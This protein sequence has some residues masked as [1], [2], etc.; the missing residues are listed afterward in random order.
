MRYY[1]N[2]ALVLQQVSTQLPSWAR[3]TSFTAALSYFEAVPVDFSVFGFG[4]EYHLVGDRID[5]GIAFPLSYGRNDLL[6]ENVLELRE[7]LVGDAQIWTERVLEP[8]RRVAALELRHS[9]MI[10]AFCL[11]MDGSTLL[12]REVPDLVYLSLRDLHRFERSDE[13]IW[14][15]AIAQLVVALFGDRPA[16]G[17]EMLERLA[18]PARAWPSLRLAHLGVARVEEGSSI[19][20][21]F[22]ATFD[23]LYAMLA[24]PVLPRVAGF[25]APLE[26]LAR[27][28][29]GLES[30]PCTVLLGSGPL[31]DRV[32]IEIPPGPH[33]ARALA[34]AEHE[35]GI[36]APRI[37]ELE[38][39]AASGITRKLV[40]GW[41]PVATRL[42]HLKLQLRA[43]AAPQWK[44][45]FVARQAG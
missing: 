7:H 9:H 32:D 4:L 18:G 35:H 10:Q 38:Q 33:F 28:G 42:S 16:P 2:P 5:A 27:F 3:G 31:L 20:P 13:V 15:P 41:V 30:T 29:E 1:D 43:G 12:A 26:F 44:A 8:A 17:T 45:Y 21:Y 37:R 11:C 19:K 22:L 24:A 14:S 40:P 6:C 23:E 34:I 36:E 25:D 39:L